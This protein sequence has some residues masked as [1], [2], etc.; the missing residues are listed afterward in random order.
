MR[1]QRIVMMAVM[2]ILRSSYL[3]RGRSIHVRTEC[4]GQCLRTES[5]V[6]YEYDCMAFRAFSHCDNRPAV[7]QWRS[8]KGW[9]WEARISLCCC[10][11]KIIFLSSTWQNSRPPKH[12]HRNT[13]AASE[14]AVS[15][16]IKIWLDVYTFNSSHET[17]NLVD[18]DS[19]HALFLEHLFKL[20]KCKPLEEC[21]YAL[22][23]CCS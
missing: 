16:N 5:M 1:S 22:P 23:Q 6:M 14:D 10:L 15:G 3:L 19:F 2:L 20:P 17:M 13:G 9:Q 18:C 4:R 7:V 11:C 21:I 8:I 12:G